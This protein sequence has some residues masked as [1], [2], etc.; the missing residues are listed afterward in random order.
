MSRLFAVTVIV[1]VIATVR[2]EAASAEQAE[3]IARETTFQQGD[4]N[5]QSANY[6]AECVFKDTKEVDPTKEAV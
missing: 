3:A 4:L 1:P 2:I 6:W 5:I